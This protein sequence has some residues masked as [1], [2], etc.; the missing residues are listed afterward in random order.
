[1]A[2]LRRRKEQLV[3]SGRVGS[4]ASVLQAPGFRRD[5]TVFRPNA[6][7]LPK[8]GS[9]PAFRRHTAARVCVTEAAHNPEVAG[10]NPTPATKKTRIRK[11]FCLPDAI[12]RRLPL[13]TVAS[14][15]A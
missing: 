5:V 8:T 2:A 6:L 14:G 12:F 9:E 1:M 3:L 7:S 10:S 11:S 13:G 15:R 4:A